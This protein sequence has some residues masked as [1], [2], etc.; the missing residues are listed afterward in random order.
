M[1]LSNPGESK[2]FER[3]RSGNARDKLAEM[4]IVLP[5]FREA[6]SRILGSSDGCKIKVLLPAPNELNDSDFSFSAYV[7]Q[8]YLNG[9]QAEQGASTRC[10]KRM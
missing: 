7:P 6:R 10:D 9:A 1:I 3:D 2:S 8:W 4:D 5:I